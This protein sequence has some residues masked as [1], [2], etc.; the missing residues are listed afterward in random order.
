MNKLKSFWIV[1]F[2][3]TQACSF[4]ATAAEVVRAGSVF[5]E[6]TEASEQVSIVKNGSK[7]TVTGPSQER[8]DVSWT[9]VQVNGQTGWIRTRSV[10]LEEGDFG[11]QKITEDEEAPH[12]FL[13]AEGGIGMLS[14]NANYFQERLGLGFGVYLSEAHRWSLEALILK[15][16]SNEALS[17]SDAFSGGVQRISFLPFIGYGLIPERLVFRAGLG[18][19]YLSGS[20]PNMEAK[21]KPTIAASIRFR[22][23]EKSQKHEWAIDIGWEHSGAARNPIF[24]ANEIGSAIACGLLLQPA[25][26]TLGPGTIPLQN[27]YSLN[28]IYFLR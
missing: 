18:L 15:P 22:P 25:G 5:K 6:T 12:G 2:L 9:P 20:N 7:V 24:P 26:C 16:F 28:F 14:S 1:C 3:L 19:S 17:S 23:A 4:V 21:L 10:Q 11:F 13:Y 8:N 27:S